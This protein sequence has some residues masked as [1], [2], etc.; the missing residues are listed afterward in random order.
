MRSCN[1]LERAKRD[2]VIKTMVLRCRV[3]KREEYTGKLSSWTGSQLQEL[4]RIFF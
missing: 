4:D 1:I 2:P 3:A